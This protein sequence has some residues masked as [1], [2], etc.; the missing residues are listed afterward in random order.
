MQKTT[1]SLAVFLLLCFIAQV[2]SHSWLACV[3]YTEK[4]GAHWDSSKCRGFPRD[5]SKYAQKDSFGMDRG[6]DHKP[7][8]DGAACKTSL[9]GGSYSASYPKAVY[10]P[11][12]QVILTHPMKNHGAATCTNIHIPDFGN[13]IYTGKKG[14]D[15]NNPYKYYRDFLISDLGVSV[16]GNQNTA[17]DVYPKPG[18]QNAPAFCENTDKAM[19]TYSFNVP[20]DIEEGEYTWV[21]RWSFNGETDIYTTCFDVIITP[22][23][24]ARDNKLM[25]R[26]ANIDL[27]VACGGSL[28]NLESGSTKGCDD[29]VTRRPVPTIGPPVTSTPRPLPTNGERADVNIYQASGEV[30]LGAPSSGVKS[31]LATL[32]FD[33]P[34][35]AVFWNARVTQRQNH[36]RSKRS[37]VGVSST[38]Y[39][40]LQETEEQVN[41]GKIYFTATFDEPCNL[42]ANPPVAVLIEDTK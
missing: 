11:G 13:R 8:M 29:V 7:G 25:D 6:F 38:H 42:E 21:W 35:D 2:R 1:L 10:Y 20:E 17:P 41:S 3:D 39:E 36:G 14:T 28:S 15:T 5:A 30:K 19:G 40:L 34:V 32:H 12:Q 27:S 22:D 26:D 31:R 18:F 9:S 37:D 4:N 16:S 33:C 23:K 24:N